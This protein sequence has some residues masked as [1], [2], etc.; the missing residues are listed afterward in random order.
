MAKSEQ[1]AQQMRE[2]LE[3]G[4]WQPG[5]KLPSLRE[6][7]R[8]AKMSLMTV[9]RAYQ[10]LESQGWIASRPQSGYYAIARLPHDAPRRQQGFQLTETVDINSFIFEVLQASKDPAI[11]PF[12]SAFP[13]P[14]LFPQRQLTRSLSV[15]A[16][17]IK[18]YSALD[19]LPPGNEN[20]RR[21][22]AQRYAMQG[23]AVA[24]EEIVIT[25]G[26]MESLNL[27]LQA[28]TQPGDYVVIESPAFY[29]ALQAIERFQLKAIEIA[30]DPQHGLDLEALQQAL[31]RYPIKACWLMPNF[32]NPR[33]GTLDGEQ[34]QALVAML[35]RYQVGLI[36]DDVYAELY[37][38]AQ[39]PLPAKAL[40]ASGA[41]LHCSSFSK[42]LVPGFR[43]GWVAAGAYA[44][45]IQRLQLMSTLSASTP[46]QLAVAEYLASN[47]YDNHLRRLRRI[48][49]QR[50]NLAY[51]IVRRHFPQDVQVNYT[52]G[53]YFLWVEMPQGLDS[54]RLY[55]MALQQGISIAPGRMFTTGDR[56][57]HCFRLNT[58]Y[59]WDK[60]REKGI[61]TLAALIHT[62]FRESAGR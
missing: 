43:I 17:H 15:V 54:T 62:L 1:L 28:L 41:I 40:D 10:L 56:F 60:R 8:H 20:L 49:E 29:G 11:I 19:N 37:Y 13:D 38:G 21:S 9:L 50:K 16:R 25:A 27:S 48:L 59:E 32:H 52:T 39:R 14:T 36:E 47:S 4:I 34:K 26:A 7:A 45:R 42:N 35:A 23:I 3:Q 61:A 5:E 12:G 46:M 2:Q 18:P 55:R 44:E 6:K 22:I 33:G 31:E 24:P 30:T 53:G 51:Q 58:S 57:N